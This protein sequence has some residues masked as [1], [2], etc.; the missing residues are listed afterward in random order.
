MYSGG[1]TQPEIATNLGMSVGKVNKII[2]GVKPP[3][4]NHGNK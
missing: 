3:K 4:E 1:A 2:K